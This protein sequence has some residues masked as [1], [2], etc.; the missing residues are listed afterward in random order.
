MRIL[1]NLLVVE[2]TSALEQIERSRDNRGTVEALVA[3]DLRDDPEI[4]VAACRVLGQFPD[5]PGITEKALPLMLT[6]P[7]IEVQQAAANLIARNSDG[8][9]ADVG[10]LWS[11]NHSNLGAQNEFE[12]YPDFPAHYAAMKFP[13]LSRRPVVLTGRFAT[14]DRLVDAG[15]RGHR[16][17]LDRQS[18]EQRAADDPAVVRT[19]IGTD[20]VRRSSRWI[21]PRS[22]GSRN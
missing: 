7:Y 15:R 3:L 9:V 5:T 16:R 2:V 12:E 22:I 1:R 20:G 19:P 21:R 4:L 8:N 14:V 13:G 11:Q 10:R 18:A 6:S 17:G